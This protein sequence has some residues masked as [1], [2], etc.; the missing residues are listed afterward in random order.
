[1]EA[2]LG[3]RTWTVEE[4]LAFEA[5]S[6]QRHEFRNG[7]VVAMAGSSYEHSA[8]EA[9][10][11]LAIGERLRGKSCRTHEGKLRVRF[12]GTPLYGYPDVLI[13]CGPPVF[14]SADKARTTILNPT[15]VIEVLSPST[16]AYDRGEKFSRYLRIESLS[17]YVLVA[18]DRSRVETYFRTG[19]GTWVF[20]YFDGLQSAAR[21][22]S[23][24]IEIP[25]AEI[26][27]DIE[28]PPEGTLVPVPV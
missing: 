18:Q 25:L 13:I 8:I 26:Y 27:A 23:L 10:T 21:F 1:M 22:R 24:E 17:E 4:Y 14:D 2:P 11:H 16:E 28:F 5:T 7:T 20:S 3:N 19:D 15:V 12:S 6:E 9:N